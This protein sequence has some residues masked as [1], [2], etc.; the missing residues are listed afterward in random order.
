MLW[1]TST[2]P[3][4]RILT[5]IAVGFVA[6]GII[7]PNVGS[8]VTGWDL[9]RIVSYDESRQKCG[10]GRCPQMHQAYCT[11]FTALGLN[12]YIY[13]SFVE[14]YPALT[15]SRWTPAGAP[16]I[17]TYDDR[18]VI[19][20]GIYAGWASWPSRD[21]ASADVKESCLL[22]YWQHNRRYN[23]MFKFPDGHWFVSPYK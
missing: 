19:S 15:K 6:L 1:R 10:S 18:E 7:Q 21:E 8:G 16:L 23:E 9:V 2:W 13:W 22:T 11:Y 17:R 20:D 12:D 3:L 4:K 5:W 14:R